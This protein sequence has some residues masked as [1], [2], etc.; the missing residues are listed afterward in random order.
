MAYIIQQRR[1]TLANWVAV[2][3]ILHDAEIGFILDMDESGKQKSSL[4]KIGDGF[5]AWNDLP[6]FGYG[7]NVYN[8]FSETGDMDTSVPSRQAVLDKLTAMNVS[9][10]E[11]LANKLSTSQLVQALKNEEGLNEDSL[12]DQIVS[13]FTLLEKFDAMDAD[14]ETLKEFAETF[15][16]AFTEYQTTIDE[17]I[18]SIQEELKKHD[19]VID[20][21][22]KFISGW[23]E[24]GE[25]DPE[26][27]E[28]TIIHHD[29]VDEK[30]NNVDKRVSDLSIKMDSKF[31]I[32]LEDDFALIDDFTIYPEGTL[33]FTYKKEEEK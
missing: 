26:T 1:D 14:I 18:L 17:T 24:E 29:S 2:N 28:P 16:P 8:D 22:D 30:I 25:T 6:L 21:H 13:R 19:D 27:G 33:F 12:K 5:T 20:S 15:G 31:N 4:Y 10:N 23:D 3:P 32:M 7:G 9:I 11:E